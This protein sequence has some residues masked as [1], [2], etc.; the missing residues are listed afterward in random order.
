MSYNIHSDVFKNMLHVLIIASN[1]L[2]RDTHSI[3]LKHFG[4][5]KDLSAQL[6]KAISKVILTLISATFQSGKE[7][8]FIRLLAI[9]SH[10]CGPR[11]GLN[12]FY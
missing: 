8:Q 11:V 5:D 2:H 10:L 1:S 9:A 4:P 6:L 3:S 7:A 12:I